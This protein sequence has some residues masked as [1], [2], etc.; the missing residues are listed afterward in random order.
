MVATRD[1]G[2]GLAARPDDLAPFIHSGAG[3]VR[4]LILA[5][6]Y[7]KLCH[8][9]LTEAAR[10]LR[11]ANHNMGQALPLELLQAL[12]QHMSREED[13]DAPDEVPDTH[14]EL[15]RVLSDF[16]NAEALSDFIACLWGFW[17]APNA[18]N[19]GDRLAPARPHASLFIQSRRLC[20]ARL[21][22]GSHN[23]GSDPP[24]GLSSAFRYSGLSP[25]PRP[26]PLAA[27]RLSPTH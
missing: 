12:G 22:L 7:S 2:R 11:G 26:P 21:P 20:A 14:V 1:D 9:G 15:Q 17:L 23:S 8:A 25:P 27:H 13:N 5:L 18:L 6:A 16:E 4:M 24:V 19:A 10:A 3:L